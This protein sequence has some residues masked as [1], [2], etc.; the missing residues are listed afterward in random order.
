MDTE[1][2]I[3]RPNHSKLPLVYN[4]T[5]SRLSGRDERLKDRID[6]GA[7]R[8]AHPRCRDGDEGSLSSMRLDTNQHASRHNVS[9]CSLKGMDHALGCDSSKGPA[10]ECDIERGA[11]NT[12]SFG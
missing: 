4:R 7:D 1:L 3:S 2:V 8:L 6:Q 5:N 12:Q 11:A 10:E 9:P